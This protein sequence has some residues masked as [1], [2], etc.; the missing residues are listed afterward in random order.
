MPTGYLTVPLLLLIVLCSGCTSRESLLDAIRARGELRVATRNSPTTYFL[1][2]DGE[3]GLEYEMARLLAKRLSVRLKII[4]VKDLQ[5]TAELVRSGQADIAA[6]GLRHR[7]ITETG[8]LPGPEYQWVTLQ[9]IYRNGRRVPESLDDIFPDQLHLLPSSLPAA[10]LAELQVRHPRLSTY[11]HTNLQT[12]DLLDMVEHGRIA[13]TVLASN[14][15]FHVRQLR[16]ELRAALAIGAPEPLAWGLP[17]AIDDLSLAGEVEAFFRELNASGQIGKLLAHFQAPVESFDY[18]DSRAFLDRWRERLPLY[19]ELFERVAAETGL[20]WRLLAA[21]GYQESH[22]DAHARSP[23]GVRGIMML[24]HDTA[25]RIGVKDRV[26]VEQSIRGG[27]RYFLDLRARLP[28]RIPE[29]DRTWMALAAYNVGL[30]HLE[31]ARVLTAR[32]GQD[33]DNWLHVREHLPLLSSEKWYPQ[34]RHGYARGFEPVRYVRN[35]RRYYHVLL[36]LTQPLPPAQQWLAELPDLE[37]P[38]LQ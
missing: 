28:A 29:P 12:A 36:Q 9:V 1:H 27:A 25:K 32:Q 21:I 22:W 31:D 23:T 26:D 38:L 8:L 33:P 34:T 37:L 13:F 18:V 17:R 3:T 30:G 5:G 10:T 16:P 2:R 35:I 15:V 20:D 7:Y 6:A 11:L 19:R 4:V 14:E 24:T